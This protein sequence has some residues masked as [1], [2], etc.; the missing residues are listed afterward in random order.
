MLTMMRDDKWTMREGIESIDKSNPDI[1]LKLVFRNWYTHLVITHVYVFVN[2][3]EQ[4]TWI[5][6]FQ[7]M[8][9]EQLKAFTIISIQLCH[10]TST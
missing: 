10:G 4:L 2:V 7:K 8:L 1:S 9:I 5:H 3:T 6:E